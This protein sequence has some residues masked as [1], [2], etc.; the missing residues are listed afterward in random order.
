MAKDADF[1]LKALL[2]DTRGKPF[3]ELALPILLTLRSP[4]LLSSDF[5]QLPLA[6]RWVAVMAYQLLCLILDCHSLGALPSTTPAKASALFGSVVGFPPEVI[7]AIRRR[8]EVRRIGLRL[9]K[10][11]QRDA[12]KVDQIAQ[13]LAQASRISRSTV[14][15]RRAEAEERYEQLMRENDALLEAVLVRSNPKKTD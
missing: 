7:A 12:D 15:R 10:E 2:G 13:R 8:E 4:L 9:I 5:D 11:T 1:R 14:Y 6:Q 3:A